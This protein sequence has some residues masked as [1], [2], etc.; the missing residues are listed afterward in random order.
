MNWLGFG[1]AFALLGIIPVWIIPTFGDIGFF[2]KI[3]ATI[4]LGV[5]IFVTVY[6]REG[7]KPKW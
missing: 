2:T 1:I 6:Y 3:L 5:I 4:V 7:S